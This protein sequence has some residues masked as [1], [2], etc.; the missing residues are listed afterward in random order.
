MG[1]HFKG[2]QTP[3]IRR[4]TAQ[5]DLGVGVVFRFS[6][7]AFLGPMFPFLF[8]CCQV[9]QLSAHRIHAGLYPQQP[10]RE[11]PLGEVLHNLE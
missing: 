1:D 9:C 3:E 8:M 5:R 7:S 4:V 2:Y 6:S 11:I 10:F